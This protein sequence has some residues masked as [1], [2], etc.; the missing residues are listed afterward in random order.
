M[1]AVTNWH[2]VSG[3]KQHT[4]ILSQFWKPKVQN[5]VVNRGAFLLDALGENLFLASSSLWWL[6]AFFGLWSH[7][8]TPCFL[9][10]V[11]T[12]LI[13]PSVIR[14]WWGFQLPLFMLYFYYYFSFAHFKYNLTLFVCFLQFPKMEYFLVAQWVKNPPAMQETHEAQF[15]SLVWQDILKEEMQLT[16]GFLPEKYHGQRSLGYNPKS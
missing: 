2:K 1:A 9:F 12:K 3:L 16:P 4:F 8:F 7:C 11:S 15:R 10:C 6:L 5:Q 14:T 13:F